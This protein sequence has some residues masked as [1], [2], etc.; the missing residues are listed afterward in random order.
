[1]KHWRLLTKAESGEG[2]IDREW[3]KEGGK[4]WVR[5]ERDRR[6]EGG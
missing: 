3:W 5:R 1:M 6:R 2:E 4:K